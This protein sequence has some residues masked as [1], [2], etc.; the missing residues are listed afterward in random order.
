MY[1]KR[2]ERICTLFMCKELPQGVDIMQDT[3][4]VSACVHNHEIDFYSIELLKNQS[5]CEKSGRSV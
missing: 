3:D 1:L 4:L 2:S 5:A